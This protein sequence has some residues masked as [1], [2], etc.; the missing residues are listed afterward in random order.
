MKKGFLFVFCII[1]CLSLVINALFIIKMF[2]KK[3][4]AIKSNEVTS[5]DETILW[6]ITGLLNSLDTPKIE[7]EFV[8]FINSSDAIVDIVDNEVLKK[9]TD[10]TTLSVTHGTQGEYIVNDYTKLNVMIVYDIS[11]YNGNYVTTLE[12]SN[13]SRIDIYKYKS[14][15]VVFS[16]DNEVKEGE[17]HLQNMVEAVELERVIYNILTDYID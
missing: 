11:S 4:E 15:F 3:E 14:F 6:G 12:E 2:S 8:V 16:I 10:N 13:Y 9:Y 17:L 1:M 5:L 7:K